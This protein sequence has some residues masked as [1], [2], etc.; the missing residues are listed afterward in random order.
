MKDSAGFGQIGVMNYDGT[1]NTI[2][3]T[4]S[5][6]GQGLDGLAFNFVDNKLYY[7][8]GTSNTSFTEVRVMDIDGGNDALVLSV[9]KATYGE[10]VSLTLS[11]NRIYVSTQDELFE[12][13]F[14]GSFISERVDASWGQ[15]FTT[16]LNY[17]AE[18]SRIVYAN[19]NHNADRG[20]YSLFLGTF[21]PSK[22]H[23]SLS[24]IYADASLAVV[25]EPHHYGMMSG[26]L[27]LG[28]AGLNRL[29]KKGIT[30]ERRIL[31][32]GCMD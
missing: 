9:D 27:L 19:S 31:K 20:I 8:V 18:T 21:V 30:H 14:T 1:G 10:F 5:A 28:A 11:H 7:T 3:K 16:S 26:L 12:T 2:I 22:R 4:G 13:D 29:R 32:D 15:D 25:P 24:N 23:S 6:G 17:D